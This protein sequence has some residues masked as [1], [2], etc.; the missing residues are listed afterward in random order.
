M[1][2][3]SGGSKGYSCPCV[4]SQLID[5]VCCVLNSNPNCVRAG[6]SASSWGVSASPLAPL[7]A[8]PLE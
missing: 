4:S 2:A 1:T 5:C 8:A 6:T 3:C 7:P